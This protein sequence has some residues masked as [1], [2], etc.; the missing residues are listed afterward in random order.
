MDHSGKSL[1]K[2]ESPVSCPV[3]PDAGAE[4]APMTVGV[5]AAV[6]MPEPQREAEAIRAGR[7]GGRAMTTGMK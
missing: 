7:Y 1:E 3:R 4:V 6:L 2:P 5:I